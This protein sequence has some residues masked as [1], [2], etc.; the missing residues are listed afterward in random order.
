MKIMLRLKKSLST[1][2]S[3]IQKKKK[4]TF[5]LNMLKVLLQIEIKI[6]TQMGRELVLRPKFNKLISLLY[7]LLSLPVYRLCHA[8]K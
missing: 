2:I 1:N 8:S 3:K 5:Q 6:S 7:I 4:I